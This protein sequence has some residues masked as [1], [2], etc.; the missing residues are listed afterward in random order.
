MTNMV[1]GCPYAIDGYPKGI[2][3][4]LWIIWED[5][6]LSPSETFICPL[7]HNPVFPIHIR[8]L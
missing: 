4:V 8:S 7:V 3:I 1:F 5:E 2:T 6:S